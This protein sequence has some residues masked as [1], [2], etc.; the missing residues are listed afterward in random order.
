[1]QKTI[2]IHNSDIFV[3]LAIPISHLSHSDDVCGYEHRLIYIL[4][5]T[6][7]A[8]VGNNNIVLN[9]R[10]VLIIS[11]GS[12]YK[13]DFSGRLLFFCFDLTNEN[14][15]N[16]SRVYPC[17][18]KVFDS[19]NLL[20]K[21]KLLYNSATFDAIHFQSVYGISDML[22]KVCEFNNKKDLLA[23]KFK[24]SL[25]TA[26]IIKAF[27]SVAGEKRTKNYIGNAVKRYIEENYSKDITI[28]EV[29][30]LLNYH[31]NYINRQIKKETGMSFHKYL[32]SVRLE[33][34]MS[35]LNSQSSNFSIEQVA[36]LVGF[37]NPKYFSTCFKKYFNITP[38]ESKKII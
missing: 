5:G 28:T 15:N 16:V 24:S 30:K 8:F 20:C 31:E 25:F 36:E 6:G 33:T 27:M 12:Q 29:S 22:L 9:K 2:E 4:E 23:N 38:S 10:D 3:R 11:A 34:A 35:I 32:L 18:K 37:S 1:M 7:N 26:A 19:E 21:Y 14:C 13:I 17:N